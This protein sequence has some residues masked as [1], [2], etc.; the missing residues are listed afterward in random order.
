MNEYDL[1]VG[2]GEYKTARPPY[3]IMT[4][5]LGSCVGIVLYDRI[6]RIGGLAHI[7]LPSIASFANAGNTGR[8]ADVAVP[9]LIERMES[10]GSSR[11]LMIA[12]IA[13]GANMFSFSQS[14]LSMDIGGRN[15][16]MVRQLLSKFSIRI[17]GEDVGG[18][19]G[20][21]MIFETESGKT[22]IR[23]VDRVIKE[24]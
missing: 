4:I 3:R 15:V 10:L 17:M 2:I 9:L 12:K 22:Y 1:I 13:G 8:F 5:G 23:T 18:N 11:R 19:V 7:M 14:S 20:R 24:I 16:N 21:T 6:N